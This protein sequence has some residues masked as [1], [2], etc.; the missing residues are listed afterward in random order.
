MADHTHSDRRTFLQLAGGLVGAA[1]VAVM[2]ALPKKLE[3]QIEWQ[4]YSEQALSAAR[5]EGKGVIIDT[6]ADW[7]IPCK[8]LDQVTFTDAGV[9]REAER[10]VRLKLN[11][12]GNDPQSEAGRAREKSRSCSPRQDPSPPPRSG[13]HRLARHPR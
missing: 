11:L 5:R 8:E 1:V 6:F 10:F 4:P 3:A 2:M 7:C 9:K 13:R 12:T